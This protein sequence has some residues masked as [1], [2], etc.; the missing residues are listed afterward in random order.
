[1]LLILMILQW[2]LV[3]FEA[4]MVSH[5]PLRPLNLFCMVFVVCCAL[6]STAIYLRWRY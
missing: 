1:M 2:C 6:Y 4:Y 3:G 5:D